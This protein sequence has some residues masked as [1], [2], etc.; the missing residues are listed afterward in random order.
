MELFE[1]H[2]IATGVIVFLCLYAFWY[3]TGGVERA[4][5]R[6]ATYNSA[7]LLDHVQIE[8]ESAIKRR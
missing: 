5:E 3:F 7:S 4:L 6:R 2:P 1:E 8:P